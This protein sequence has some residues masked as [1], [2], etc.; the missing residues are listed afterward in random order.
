MYIGPEFTWL[1]SDRPD[2]VREIIGAANPP[3]ELNSIRY[4]GVKEVLVTSRP[5]ISRTLKALMWGES[6]SQA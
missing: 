2:D 6:T 4:R 5:S 3:R 1:R